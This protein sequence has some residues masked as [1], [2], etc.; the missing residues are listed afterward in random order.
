MSTNADRNLLFGLLALKVGMIDQSALVSAFHAWTRDKS[1]TIA[2][3]LIES[4]EI[5]END[6]QLLDGLAAKHLKRHGD[7]IETSL[8]ALTA[9][10]AVMAS[11]TEAG[12]AEINATLDRVSR[13]D[14]KS[15]EAEADEGVTMSM[16]RRVGE[17]ERFRLLRPHARGGLGEV[18][19]AL[20]AE[21]NREV[22]LKQILEHHADDL[23]SRTRFVLEAEITGGLEHPGIVPVYGLG[24]HGSGRPYY[25]MRFV[26]G[27]SLKEAIDTFHGDSKVQGDP[28]LRSLGL[29]KLL[30]R[31]TDVC[32]AIEYAHT[33][34]VIHR[35]IKPA[36]VIVGKHGETLVVDWGLAKPLGHSEPGVSSEERTLMPSS[37]SGTAET[38]PGS[39]MGTPAFMSPEQSVGDI[40]TIGTRSDV[41]SLGATLY[42]LLTGKTAFNGKDLGAV[43]RAVKDGKFPTPRSVAPEIDRALEAICLKA[44]AVDPKDRY[45]SAKALSD[46]VERWTADEPVTAYREPWRRRARR[47]AKHNRTAVTAA[48]A[49]LLV[50]IVGMAAVLAV[51]TRA[52]ANLKA[53]NA[54]VTK[55]NLELAEANKRENAR[56]KLAVEAVG[57]FHKGVSEDLLL[58]QKEFGTLRTR[59][60]EGAKGFYQ[61]LEGMLRDNTDTESRWELG[62]VYGELAELTGQLGS[63]SDGLTLRRRALAI[64]EDLGKTKP[65]DLDVQVEILGNRSDLAMLLWSTGQTAEG[66]AMVKPLSRIA[67]ARLDACDPSDLDRR[68][69][70]TKVLH[71]QGAFIAYDSNGNEGLD[72]LRKAK[73]SLENLLKRRPSSEVFRL[74]LV[75]VCDSLGMGLDDQGKRDEAM[76]N[77]ERG[78]VL[79]EALFEANP[80]D[81]TIGKELLRILGNMAVALEGAGQIER[82]IA[83]YEQALKVIASTETANPALRSISRNRAWIEANLGCALKRFGRDDEALARFEHARK[84]RESLLKEDSSVVRDQT[85]LA[86]VHSEMADVHARQGRVAKARASLESAMELISE[87]AKAHPGDLASQSSQAKYLGQLANLELKAGKT[88]VAL[89]WS[90][91][92]VARI[93]G[94]IQA[95]P[96]QQPIL[97]DLM[98]SRGIILQKSGEASP[99]AAAFRES[100]RLLEGLAHPNSGDIYNLACSR[101]LLSGLAQTAGSGISPS[102][103]LT[104]ADK[105]MKTLRRAIAM[106]WSNLAEMNMDRDLDPLRARSDFQALVSELG[107]PANPFAV[108]DLGK[109]K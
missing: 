95:D 98:T 9:P 83:L 28:G 103:A 15:M 32:N 87:L 106:G 102:E 69:H 38:L 47:W 16:G 13:S 82:A 3:L 84:A 104:E 75:S 67:E 105:A 99:A 39:A 53:A 65:D 49:S 36:N 78:R 100:I 68:F 1:R 21:L 46:D 43:L 52:N 90:E 94:L 97:A 55:A 85:E 74:E 59:L 14:S 91:K 31:F 64:F 30:R 27:E 20:D 17:G 45:A 44:M 50:A 40:E 33:R 80:T 71:E 42:Y 107:F 108:E 101:S 26:R 58:R 109:V 18:F 66:L 54:K 10:R 77:Y 81:T 35:D 12:D 2:E 7:D 37:A 60:L 61:R 5:D 25:A 41:Y 34:G 57:M 92:A 24:T 72:V 48:A 79:G 23:N 56:F 86:R 70:L 63:L 11:L 19:V 22:A 76:T 29:R 73:E 89:A 93:R 6:R 8:A 4:G 88:S 62:K 96:S 51:E